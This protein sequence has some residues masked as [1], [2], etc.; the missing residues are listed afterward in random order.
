M[1]QSHAITAVVILVLLALASK[2]KAAAA[3]MV[4]LTFDPPAGG[5]SDAWISGAG[6]SG[7]PK[8][9][10]LQIV[11][12]PNTGGDAGPPTIPPTIYLPRPYVPP[13]AAPDPG[14]D[15]GPPVLPIVVYPVVTIGSS[16]LELPHIIEG[17]PVEPIV[18]PIV[19]DP[20]IPPP[21]LP[22]FLPA[23]ELPEYLARYYPE[24][25]ARYGGADYP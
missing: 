7:K 18:D 14:G 3:P 10:L 12:V 25:W 16:G 8:P 22:P 1:K 24:W 4:T 17:I 9:P 13:A 19:L 21:D 15:A 20:Y 5:A 23:G 11:A 6:P 2:A